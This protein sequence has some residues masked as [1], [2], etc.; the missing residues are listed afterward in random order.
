MG[1]SG[2]EAGLQVLHVVHQEIRVE[3]NK[4]LGKDA[5]KALE[6]S[7]WDSYNHWMQA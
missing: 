3:E 4:A 1:T 7:C 2:C 5:Q 6:Q